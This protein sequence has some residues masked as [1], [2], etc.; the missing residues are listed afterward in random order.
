MNNAQLRVRLMVSN[1]GRF[2]I[3]GYGEKRLNVDVDGCYGIQGSKISSQS[4]EA[5][6][7]GG[8]K[9]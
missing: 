9:R 2:P 3:S 8:T 6:K 1:A 7:V 5:S 4:L